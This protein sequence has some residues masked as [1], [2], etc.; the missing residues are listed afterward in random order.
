ML[1]SIFLVLDDNNVHVHYLLQCRR[2]SKTTQE[3]DA[4]GNVALWMTA[5]FSRRI[6]LLFVRCV[7]SSYP[8]PWL[9][10]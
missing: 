10:T 1:V 8:I 7:S 5:V 4:V 9:E 6:D 3:K 2:R